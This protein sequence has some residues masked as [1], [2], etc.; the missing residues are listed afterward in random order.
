SDSAMP[1]FY[2]VTAFWG[3]LDG[4]LL[5]WVLLLAVFSALAVRSNRR[6][7]PDLIPH[8][9]WVL[10]VI[11]G[12]FVALLVFLK[13]P[14]NPYLIEEHVVGRGLNPLLQNIYM[15]IHPPSLYLGYVSQAI[16]F[17]FGIA[18]L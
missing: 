9:V 1:L 5:F 18:A 11:T 15:I 13:N 10:A 17:S 2:K 16:P 14:F 7:H 4:S 3:G 6:R 12:F 8:V